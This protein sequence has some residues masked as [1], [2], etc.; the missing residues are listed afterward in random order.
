[1]GCEDTRLNPMD[2]ST[3]VLSMYVDAEEDPAADE[4]IL[5]AAI[6]QSLL[7]GQLGFNPWYTEH[8]FRGPWH[9]APIQ[10]AAYIAPQLPEE[11]YLGFGVLSVPYHHPVRLVEQMNQLDQLTKGHT[12]FGL[13]SGFPGIEPN[14][15][16]LDAEYHRS[17]QAMRDS[18]AVMEG[19]WSLRPG[20]PPYEFQTELWQG[21]VVKRIAPSAY[22]RS[23]PT[24]IRTA[25]ND[26]ATREA[27]VRGWPAFLGSFGADLS[28]QWPLYRE[29]LAAAGHPDHVIAE[30]LRWSTV[31][32]L[33]VVVAERDEDAARLV[34]LAR[35]ERMALRRRFLAHAP[36]PV[37]GPA[38]TRKGS[39]P[40]P[41]QF[42]AG[43]DMT[44]VIAG[45]PERVAARV[46]ELE[47][48]GVNHLLLRFLG[49][50]HGETR[51]IAEQSLRLF[52]ERVM[53]EFGVGVGAA[54][55]S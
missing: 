9:S 30:C 26:E 37:H 41:A 16:G 40:T 8:H 31:D 47:A 32:W 50:W 27:A 53:T 10:F 44:D 52:S 12:L 28:T 46:Q 15:A 6:D 36:E 1:M 14:S 20:D 22:R 7:A 48:L 23:R 29:T 54:T 11:R 43:D 5:R 24:I 17:G 38:I 35:E 51:W 3:M 18:F 55:G 34:E 33:S 39:G 2:F 21:R 19:L 42:A 49:E 13:G 25:R 4:P 45:S